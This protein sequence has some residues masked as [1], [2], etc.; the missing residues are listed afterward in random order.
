MDGS[1]IDQASKTVLALAPAFA[2][3]FAVQQ[4][5][6]I[7]DSV[8]V[9]RGN[10]DPTDPETIPRKKAI[11]S[12]ISVGI[13]ALLVLLDKVDFNVLTAIGAKNTACLRKKS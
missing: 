1:T 12:L 6:E 8:V 5:I 9:W 13:A 10:W 7:I 2:A 3:G 11:L 4:F